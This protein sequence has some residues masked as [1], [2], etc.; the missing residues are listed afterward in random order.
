MN[1]FYIKRVYS[2][3]VLLVDT[4]KALLEKKLLLYLNKNN[5]AIIFVTSKAIGKSLSKD[6]N[7]DFYYSTREKKNKETR[8]SILKDFI[9]K[10]EKTLLITTLILEIG[11]D[12][13]FIT[14]TI[15]LELI[16]SLISFI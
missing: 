12:F 7:I 9:S 11:I 16:Y 3:K 4:L 13:S 8:D 1:I 5:K 15:S 2:S 6:L 14:Y 10:K